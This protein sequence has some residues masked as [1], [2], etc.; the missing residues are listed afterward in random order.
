MTPEW[1]VPGIQW[2]RVGSRVTCSPPPTD[3]DEDFLVYDRFFH[4][5]SKLIGLGFQCESYGNLYEKFQSYRLG[6]ANVILTT[7]KEFYDRF[8]FATRV[9]K[10]LNLMKKEDRIT[11]FA[12]LLDGTVGNES[13]WD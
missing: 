9:A 11:L 4:Q 7:N 6:D 13:P 2:Q 12:A 5:K 1:I 3:T 10:R 8:L